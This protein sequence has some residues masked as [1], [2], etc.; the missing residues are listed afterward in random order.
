MWLRVEC[1]AVLLCVAEFLQ[2]EKLVRSDSEADSGW[3]IRGGSLVL[4]K[5]NSTIAHATGNA[6]RIEG[7]Q[8]RET[9]TGFATG[10][11]SGTDTHLR[12]GESV[13]N[14]RAGIALR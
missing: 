8:R 3:L 5:V 11:S 10:R 2:P 9:Q 6:V 12:I 4:S 7:S 13:W 14:D 1:E